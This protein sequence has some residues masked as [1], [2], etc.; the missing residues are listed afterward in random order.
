M[1]IEGTVK[2]FDAE[3]NSVILNNA[4]GDWK[5]FIAKGV[6]TALLREGS[7]VSCEYSIPEGKNYKVIKSVQGAN[8]TQ[9]TPKPPT[10][11]NGYHKTVDTGLS[12]VSEPA[13]RFIS[14]CVGQAIIAGLITDKDAIKQWAIAAHIAF[15]SL[16]NPSA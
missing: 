8:V 10:N 9:A 7:G 1:N 5:M 4:Q 14:N 16:E 6:S 12:N 2:S 15:K 3:K 11:G 13:L